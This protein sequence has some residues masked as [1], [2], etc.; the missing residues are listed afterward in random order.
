[1]VRLC[2]PTCAPSSRSSW[3]GCFKN[4]SRRPNSYINSRVE[5]WMVSPRKSRRKSACFSRTQTSTPA[6]ARRKPSIMPAGPPP[7]MQQRVS[8]VEDMRTILQERISETE[9]VLVQRSRV[10]RAGVG[11]YFGTA[12][13]VGRYRNFHAKEAFNN[14]RG[15]DHEEAEKVE[16][17]F[18]DLWRGSFCGESGADGGRAHSC[19]RPGSD[20]EAAGWQAKARGQ[21]GGDEYAGDER[22]SSASRCG[23]RGERGHVAH[24]HEHERAYVHD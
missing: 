19:A 8:I 2:R 11:W 9:T 3:C 18:A 23:A 7:A 4:S 21:H 13:R 20:A 16:Q 10:A 17:D 12:R 1:M 24:G 14:Y 5:G 22:R 15:A 6:R